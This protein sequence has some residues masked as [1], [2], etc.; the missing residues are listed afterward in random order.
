MFLK[1][2]HDNM[3]GNPTDLGI[4]IYLPQARDFSSLIKEQRVAFFQGTITAL[5]SN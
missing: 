1:H 4:F 3:Q 2:I 5:E